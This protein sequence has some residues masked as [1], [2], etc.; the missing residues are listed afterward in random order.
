MGSKARPY[1]YELI[2]AGSAPPFL[3]VSSTPIAEEVLACKVGTR[4]QGAE[5]FPDDFFRNRAQPG[6][7]VEAAVGVRV[8]SSITASSATRSTASRRLTRT[9]ISTSGRGRGKLPA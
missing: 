7:G 2:S 5:L 1:T 9:S 6:G 8:A 3:L 4:A